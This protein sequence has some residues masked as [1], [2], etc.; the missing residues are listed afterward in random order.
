MDF[1]VFRAK[2]CELSHRDFPRINAKPLAR[3]H[4]RLA[5]TMTQVAA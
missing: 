4:R 3:H 2:C 1:G 5:G